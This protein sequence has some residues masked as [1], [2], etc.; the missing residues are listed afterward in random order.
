[1]CSKLMK[2]WALPSL[3][4]ETSDKSAE[5]NVVRIHTSGRDASFGIRFMPIIRSA[6]GK[7]VIFTDFMDEIYN[8]LQDRVHVTR[9]AGQISGLRTSMPVLF[10]VQVWPYGLR[11]KRF[12]SPRIE[13]L[14]TLTTH[15]SSSA[16][17]KDIIQSEWKQWR[18]KVI[19]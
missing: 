11:C 8:F 3:K 15:I 13:R 18:I 1:M 5:H 17:S 10:G 2:V 14:N 16:P 7:Q 6:I 9:F 4:S 19:Y 12:E